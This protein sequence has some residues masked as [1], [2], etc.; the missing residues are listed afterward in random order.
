M[1]QQI[2]QHEERLAKNRKIVNGYLKKINALAGKQDNNN[3]NNKLLNLKIDKN[4]GM[5]YFPYRRFIIVLEVPG[6]RPGHLYV[7][8]CV[9][10]LEKGDSRVKVM[11]KSMQ[12]NFMQNGTRDSI[13]CKTARVVRRWAWTVMK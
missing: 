6:D 7:Y 5:C 11:E 9:C 2:R 10:R 13:L 3:N 8:T 12:L 4:T 1:Q